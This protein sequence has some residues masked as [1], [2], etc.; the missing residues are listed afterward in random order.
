MNPADGEGAEALR[1][2]IALG[3]YGTAEDVAAAVVFF[4]SPSARHISGSGLSVD[5]GI[6][7]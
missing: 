4:A 5:G 1:Q 6:N 3:R 7:A 2:Q